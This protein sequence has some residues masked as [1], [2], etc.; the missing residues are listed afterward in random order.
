MIAG[1]PNEN[2]GSPV[3]CPKRHIPRFSIISAVIN[4]SEVPFFKHFSR[5]PK[6]EAAF[7]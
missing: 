2:H 5:P 7:S 4:S 1:C 3:Q 6:I